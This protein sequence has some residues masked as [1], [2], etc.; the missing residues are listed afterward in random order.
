MRITV[1]S[2]GLERASTLVNARVPA[3]R[4]GPR[5][6]GS[7][8][9]ERHVLL[10]DDET[11][12]EVDGQYDPLAETLTFVATG[13]KPG[14]ARTFS[15]DAGREPERVA[16][17]AAT[18]TAK[19]DRVELNVG[20]DRFATYIVDGT[21]RPYFW[22]VLGPAGASVVRGQGSADHPHH[23]GLCLSYGG[24]SEG[25][26]VNI[27]SDWDEPPY[28]P[29][30]RMLHRGFRRLRGGPVF[31]EVVH[32]L[33]YLD[34]DGDPFAE[35]VRTVRWWWVGEAARFLDI[36]SRIVTVTDR[37][38]RPFIVMIRTPGAFHDAGR[39]TPAPDADRVGESRRYRAGWVDA[40]GP[41]GGPPPGAPEGP[42]EELVDQP[43]ARPWTQPATG[44]WN[45]IALFD[46]PGNDGFPNMIGKYATVQQITQTHYPP[47]VAP[48]GP[49]SYRS[50]V[51]VHDGDADA[52]G[53]G[54]RAA[55]Y[56]SECRAEVTD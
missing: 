12:R 22:P 43:G 2:G 44:P 54:A 4:L 42:P 1:H 29:G 50:R 13:L 23:T 32:D 36:E 14:E 11:G 49:F 34:V 16:A 53:V 26:S 25:G 28:G 9:G 19:L 47:A 41:T 7:D 55:D 37:G 48:A 27:W 3:G 30:G 52:A 31:G 46:H 17:F 56:S 45:G 51:L 35:E 40:S 33:T 20:G 5:S 39:T 18:A 8:G 24:H 38:P 21:R 10:R 15:I 6:A